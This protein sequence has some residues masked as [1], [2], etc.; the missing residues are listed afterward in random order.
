MDPASALTRSR[1]EE[2]TAL[3]PIPAGWFLMGC[4][5]GQDNEK[6][7]HRVWIDE[8]QLAACQVTNTGYSLF[9]RDTRDLPPPFWNDP[10]FNHL[11]QPVVGVSWHEAVR[12]CEWLS[13]RT[14]RHLR[15]PT[16][17]EWE[18]AARGGREG[19]LFPWGNNPPQSLD[20]YHDRWKTGPEPVGRAEPSGYGLYNMC[21]NVHEWCAD[22]YAPGYYAISPER[23]PR[24]PETGDRR[25]SRGGSWRHHI[26]MSRCA[27]RS[28]IPPAFQYADY[29]FRVACGAAV[30]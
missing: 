10:N 6:P 20:G 26:K 14:N 4:D 25:A 11:E 3:I 2:L 9:L 29:G 21:D 30:V 18:R 17:A 15:L 22:W 13:A 28:S 8:F 27:A 23:N 7:V 1:P 5:S 12:Y 19:T 16:E 24:G